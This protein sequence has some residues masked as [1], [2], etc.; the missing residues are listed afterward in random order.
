MKG[1]VRLSQNRAEPGLLHRNSPDTDEE[2]AY[3]ILEG[4]GL[5]NAMERKCRFKP[6]M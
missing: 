4:V 6:G 1:K 2:E 3:Y 5:F